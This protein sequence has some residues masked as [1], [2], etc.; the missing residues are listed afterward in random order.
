MKNETNLPL[1]LEIIRFLDILQKNH[2][3]QG[4]L[5]SYLIFGKYKIKKET[6][7]LCQQAEYIEG[8]LNQG[9][10]ITIKGIE[11]LERHKQNKTREEQT[12]AQNLLA[13]GMFAFAVLTGVLTLIYYVFDL[14]IRG[15]ATGSVGIYIAGVFLLIII[16][17]GM[18]KV[19]IRLKK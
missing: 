7:E 18:K 8:N 17:L 16:I 14:K 1:I 3:D 5:N 13:F 2:F 15:E 9:W 12:N 10:K 19:S 6:I 11:F 4:K